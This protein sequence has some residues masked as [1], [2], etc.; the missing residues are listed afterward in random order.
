MPNRKFSSI[1][2]ETTLAS[3]ISNSATSMTVATGTGPA[4]IQG[5]GFTNGDQFTVAIDPDTSNEEIV[6]ITAQ[7]SD[8]FTITRARASSSGISH[9]GGATVRH[10]LTSDD[11]DAFESTTQ[12]A[13]TTTGTQTLSNKTLTAPK[14]VNGGFIADANGNEEIKFATTTSAVNEITVTNAATGNGPTIAASGGDTNINLNLSGKGTGE[15]KINGDAVGSSSV[16]TV[17][18][19]MGA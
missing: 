3:G 7:S 10:V 6:F 1:S 12:N 2:V 13:V 16:S 15:V 8:T 4:L 5:S 17:F 14:F 11:L 18:M 19:L 9:S